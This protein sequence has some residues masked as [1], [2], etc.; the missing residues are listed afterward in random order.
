MDDNGLD[1]SRE[2][3]VAPSGAGHSYGGEHYW[4]G[5]IYISPY[6][7]PDCLKREGFDCKLC[8]FF[9]PETCRLL[10]VPFMMQDVRS[11]FETWRE[12]QRWQLRRQQEL[13]RAVRSE[14]QAHGRALHYAVLARIV[15]DR[16]PELQVSEYSVLRIMASHPDIFERVAEGVYRCR[17][18]D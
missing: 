4:I 13:I 18:A 5:G 10:H 6:D 8:Q 1:E 17:R 16:H 9:T 11:I 3:D 15:E 12:R 14:L 7:C 2:E